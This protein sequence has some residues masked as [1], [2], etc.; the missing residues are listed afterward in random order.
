MKRVVAIAACGFSLAGCSSMPSWMPASS[1]RAARRRRTTMQF[2]SEPAGAEART[3]PG[4]ACR[5]PCSLA[6]PASEFTVSFALPGYPAADRAGAKCIAGGVDPATG[7]ARAPRL[8]PNPVFVELQPAAPPPPPAARTG[9]RQRPRRGRAPPPWRRAAPSPA[10][11]PASPRPPAAGA[12]PGFAVAA[13]AAAE[14]PRS[15]AF[16]D[17]ARDRLPK[18]AV[19]R[20]LSSAGERS[21]HTGE[22]V[23]SIPT[24][25]T[26]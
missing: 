12:G 14:R 4:Q 10:P 24:A 15:R 1:C 21:L 20:A 25:P 11:A 23:G 8:V 9:G 5:T 26:I 7:Q 2:E 19:G 18:S 17:T 16:L 22:V 13:A 3:S 6:V